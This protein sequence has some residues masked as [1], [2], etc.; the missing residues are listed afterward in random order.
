MNYIINLIT[1]NIWVIMI[2]LVLMLFL[3]IDLS[4]FI[5]EHLGGVYNFII[6]TY[7]FYM[8]VGLFMAIYYYWLYKDWLCKG[9]LYTF[10]FITYS[11]VVLFDIVAKKLIN[12]LKSRMYKYDSKNIE[13]IKR[14]I[15]EG[16]NSDWMFLAIIIVIVPYTLYGFI[17]LLINWLLKALH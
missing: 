8:P 7:L 4:I 13:F 11:I 17:R 6:I 3:I 2:I 12:Y 16:E 5:D 10:S 1:S 9:N 15:D 14:K